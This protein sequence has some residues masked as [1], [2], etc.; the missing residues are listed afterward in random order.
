VRSATFL[1]FAECQFL[2]AP[3]APLGGPATLWAPLLGPWMGASQQHAWRAAAHVLSMD[4]VHLP[5]CP[6]GLLVA[7]DLHSQTGAACGLESTLAGCGR[8]EWSG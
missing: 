2:R 7:D 6:S 8:V 3:G 5:P 1:G 4:L